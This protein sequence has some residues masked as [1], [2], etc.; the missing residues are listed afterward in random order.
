MAHSPC[1]PLAALL[2]LLLATMLLGSR[3]TGA[4]CD[5]EPA[6]PVCALGGVLYTSACSAHAAGQLIA[7]PGACKS[8][9][10]DCPAEW[11][12]VCDEPSGT[13]YG[14]PCFAACNSAEVGNKNVGTP[15]RVVIN[16][17]CSW[18]AEFAP[19]CGAD[20]KTYSNGGDA[21]RMAEF[22]PVCGANNKTYSNGGEAYC[23][24]VPVQFEGKCKDD[25]NGGGGAS[26]QPSGCDLII[27]I[28]APV[29]GTD[30]TTYG[31]SEEARCRG[32][33]VEHEG[34]CKDGGDNDG[35]GASPQPSGC[36]MI[37][38]LYAPVCGTDGQTYGNS[39]EARCRGM[40]V[41]HEGACKDGGDNDGSGASPPPLGCD[42]IVTLYAPVCGADG[43]TYGNS[44]EAR[45]RG[46]AVQHEDACEGGSGT[47]T[48]PP[49]DDA[50]TSDAS[51]AVCGMDNTTYASRC[52]AHA[53]T[54]LIAY[55]GNCTAACDACEGGSSGWAP[56]CGSN[57]V[58]YGSTC[59]AQCAGGE[60]MEF[61]PATAGIPCLRSVGA[62]ACIG[63]WSPVCGAD[64]KTYSNT[65]CAAC[66]EVPTSDEGPCM[67]MIMSGSPM[68]YDEC[69][70]GECERSAGLSDPVCM[71][72][73][74]TLDTPMTYLNG[75]FGKCQTGGTSESR[76]Y[77]GG[78]DV[79]CDD[80]CAP[81]S[82]SGERPTGTKYDEPVCCP[83]A[84][85]YPSKCY[86]ECFGVT[87]VKTHCFR[88]PCHGKRA[89]KALQTAECAAGG[90]TARCIARPC[91]AA[92][93]NLFVPDG[94]TC[95]DNYCQR[96]YRLEFLGELC[97][98]VVIDRWGKIV[99]QS[100]ATH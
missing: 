22:A 97:A 81:V 70:R 29:C 11:S 12:P 78:C 46:V 23:F 77:K 66:W 67:P 27:A 61:D 3:V 16:G 9:C 17:G 100:G 76:H 42:M 54:M 82:M 4:Q 20:N 2:P 73:E 37:I 48:S 98:P 49:A 57:D 80:K 10:A 75:C 88:G 52:A 91:D 44:E 60:G 24:E 58:T 50:C 41:E 92:A 47:P 33:A 59:F 51:G 56:V 86:A 6:G 40:A 7:Y 39:E 1:R 55:S 90:S 18:V 35:S 87:D 74:P 72:D 15:C 62:C 19:V 26:P 30:G 71:V 93:P 34:E 83:G 14:S 13:T 69:A 84:I 36:D 64:G 95:V 53:A 94:A 25:N 31:N 63:L 65:G 96:F 45:C 43:K 99:E 5:E 89:V 85:E 68:S 79:T 8:E 38:T 21:W 32:V 28:Y